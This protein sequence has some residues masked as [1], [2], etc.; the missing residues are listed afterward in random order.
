VLDT[1]GD[2]KITKPWNI[3]SG[4]GSQLYQGRHRGPAAQAATGAA[5]PFDA[6]LDTMGQLQHV[7]P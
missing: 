7:T 6:K 1:N 5:R 2:G 3:A 4:A